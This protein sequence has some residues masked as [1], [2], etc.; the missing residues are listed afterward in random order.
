LIESSA[1]AFPN[2]GILPA[3]VISNS[4]LNASERST[5]FKEHAT[6]DDIFGAAVNDFDRDLIIARN[7]TIS[8]NASEK[9]T[10]GSAGDI[11]WADDDLP[12]DPYFLVDRDIHQAYRLYTDELD[13]F[14]F[15][16]A[17][18][19]EDP[20]SG[21]KYVKPFSLHLVGPHQPQQI[22]TPRGYSWNRIVEVDCCSKVYFM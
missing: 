10:I 11:F 5:L 18:V 7:R 1:R 20:A 22:R 15:A 12:F 21:D 19:P 13:A 4:G 16:I 9:E 6:L 14:A 17:T 8:G 2:P 3:T